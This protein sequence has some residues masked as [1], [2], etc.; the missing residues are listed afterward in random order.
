MN[1][2]QRSVYLAM[3]QQIEKPLLAH[4]NNPDKTGVDFAE[5]M[6]AFH[7][8]IA[9]QATK[10][11][12]KEVLMGLLMSYKPIAEVLVTIPEKA[13][14]FVDDFLNAEEILVAEEAEEA[15]GGEA[16]AGDLEP[17]QARAQAATVAT[18]TAK[19][20]KKK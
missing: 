3:L 19:G 4:L 18:A 2:I 11:L 16:D 7:G 10:A 20:G 6:M 14:Q 13:D 17:P 9:Y 12:G 15:G 8:D 1:V 5:A